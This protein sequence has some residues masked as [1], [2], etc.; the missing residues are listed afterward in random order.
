MKKKRC[1][2]WNRRVEAEKLEVTIL[3]NEAEGVSVNPEGESRH[4]QRRAKTTRK[5]REMERKDGRNAPGEEGAEIQSPKRRVIRVD[6][7]ETQGYVR[8]NH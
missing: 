7:E 1:G 6:S 2:G 3:W 5:E 4:E 8:R